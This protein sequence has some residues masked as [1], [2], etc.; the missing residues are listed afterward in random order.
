MTDLTTPTLS[1]TDRVVV[2]TGGTR[3]IGRALA[4][5]LAAAGATLVVLARD[6]QKLS[7]LESE[8]TTSGATVATYAIDLGDT[9]AVAGTFERI[10]QTHGRIDGLVNNAGITKVGPTV[11]YAID[12]AR[13]ILDVNVLGL[14]ACSQAAA[15]QMDAGGSIVNVASLSSFI[16]QPERTAYVA[17]KAAV[18]GMTKSMAVEWGPLG[19]RVNA[20]APGYIETD[21]SRALMA[22][23]PE[24]RSLVENR[25]PLRRFGRPEDL[26]G[27]VLFL[28]GD[29]SAFVSGA[30]LSV[31]GGWLANGFMR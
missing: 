17:S 25:T 28:L 20:I 19:I 4:D 31:D 6:E 30:H 2:L 9:D 11:D 10:A 14:L 29:H 16:G 26:V 1:L 13:R 8:L 18:I 3:G 23:D 24:Y 12:D 5:G 22:K 27:A 7:E 21:L 15:R